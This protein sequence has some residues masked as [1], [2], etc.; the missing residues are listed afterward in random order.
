LIYNEEYVRKVLPFIRP[1]YFSDN[2]EKIVFKEIFEFI[3][4]YKNPP[5]YEALV[6]NFTEKKTLTEPQ[7]QEAIELLNKVHS[8][9]DE[10]TETQWLIE[11]TEKFC[12]DKA[13]YNAIMES[14]SI[15]DS[16][17]EKRTKGEIPQLLSD[18]LGVSFD[19]NIGHDYTQDYDSRYDSYHKVES[20][21][22]FDLDLFNKITK[23]GLPIKT[24][25]IAL[26]GTGVGKSLFMCHVAAGNMSQGQNVLYITMEMAE[27]KIAERIDA[28]L[29]N[30]DLDEL[31][32]ISKE[33]YTRKFSALKSK[34]QGKLI[35]K[36]YPTAGASV[37]H[38]RALLNDL[39]LKKNFRPDI[40]FIDY[41][42]IC[43]SARIKPGANVNS[44][45]YI[46]AIAEELRGLAV[47]FSVPVV[48]ATQT[49]RS[50]FSNSDP[51]LEDTSESFGLPATA[52]FMFALVSNEELEALNQI[53]VKQLKNR[54]GDPNLY[55]RFVLGIDRAKM[56]LYDVEES[57]Q[58][59][60]AD[61]GIP[62]KPLNTF[63]NRERRK[64]FGGLK[65]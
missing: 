43:C 16:K 2:A 44:Y 15:L 24:L 65:V 25:N 40:I 18:A 50:G 1:D 22:R 47:E 9:K 54:Y 8:D 23:G 58:Q 3:N 27:E 13:I 41:L 64:D 63:G 42:N 10:P 32:T 56:R 52:D 48:S 51:G 39:A 12:Q 20:R 49:T 60:I 28:N 37:L 38:F 35:I 5:T 7:V 61:A 6:I 21:I 62:D 57:A 14:V 30:I 34:T 53:L 33:D 19:N 45:S 11:Q 31:R 17:G 26:A 55:K 29:L 59:D 46:K 36:E 4:Q